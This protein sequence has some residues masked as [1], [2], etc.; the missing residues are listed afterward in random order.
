MIENHKQFMEHLF[1]EKSDQVLEIQM[2]FLKNVIQTAIKLQKNEFLAI[3]FA[4]TLYSSIISP[5][6]LI[7]E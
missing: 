1:K 5:R 7:R 4:L 6:Y 3:V 2:E